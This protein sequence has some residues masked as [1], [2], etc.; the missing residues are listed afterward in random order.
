MDTGRRQASFTFHKPALTGRNANIAVAAAAAGFDVTDTDNLINLVHAIR[1]ADRAIYPD[2]YRGLGRYKS[3]LYPDHWVAAE[4][5]Q[6]R[7]SE[8]RDLEAKLASV[9]TFDVSAQRSLRKQLNYDA[10]SGANREPLGAKMSNK[11][12][13]DDF[14]PRPT[15]KMRKTRE[16]HTTVIKSYQSTQRITIDLTQEEDAVDSSARPCSSHPALGDLTNY[17]SMVPGR[18]G[19]N[20]QEVQQ[21]R[22]QSIRTTTNSSLH[23]ILDGLK[24]SEANIEKDREILKERW[25]V[26]VDL[27]LQSVTEDLQILN[28]C[29]LRAKN[30]I[31]EAITI[32]ED[33]LL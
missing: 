30:A 33:R 3:D 27:Q 32:V 11:R 12:T 31:R 4:M 28:E 1:D 17:Q 9:P 8:D 21:F 19:N 22:Q 18:Y 13:A 14:T 24:Q 26:D 25:D 15:S 16:D 23:R 6:Q 7:M 29:F 5:R 10:S 2:R 20:M